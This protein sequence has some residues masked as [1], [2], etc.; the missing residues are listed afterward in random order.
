MENS[1]G[2]MEWLTESDTS[3]SFN[4]MTQKYIMSLGTRNL[5][6]ALLDSYQLNDGD[7]SQK[8]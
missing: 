8:K 3:Q 4:N 1:L 2:E 6:V 5:L 7:L